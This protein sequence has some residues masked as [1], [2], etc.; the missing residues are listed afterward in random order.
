MVTL[1]EVHAEM[2]RLA[3]RLEAATDESYRVAK[4]V[5]V[6]SAAFEEAEAVAWIEVRKELG[7]V[8]ETGAKRLAR[9]YEA[10]VALRVAAVATDLF[11]AKAEDKALDN[12]S[13]NLRQQ[14]SAAQ[15][16]A[17]AMKEEMRMAGAV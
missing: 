11:A 17:A 16:V 2:Q 8:D 3:K 13:R 4:R 6:A 5:S 1:F 10:Q 7:N 12:A 14:L 15:T 9:D